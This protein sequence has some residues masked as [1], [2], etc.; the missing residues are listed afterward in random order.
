MNLSQQLQRQ[1]SY[2]KS[3]GPIPVSQRIVALKSLK[4]TIKQYE[5]ALE[6]AL[7]QDLG[8]SAFEAY[9]SEIGFIYSSIDYTIKHLKKWSRPHRV[10][11]DMAQLIGTSYVYPSAYGVVLIIGPFNYPV[12]LLLEP[13]VGAIAGGNGAILKPSELTPTVERVLVSLIET[14]FSKDYVSIVTGGV[15][16][17]QQ[18]LDLPFDY[19]FFTGSA[20]VGKIVMQKASQ[21]LIP[22]TLELGG[23]SPVI[24]DETS[25]LKLAA[26]RLAWGKFMN[27]GQTCVAPDYALVHH[28]IYDEFLSILTEVIQT[29]YGENPLLSEDYGRIV[30]TQH[31]K[32]LAKLIDENKDKLII[33]GEVSLEQ[34]YIAPTVFKDVQADDTLMTEEI[35]GPLLPTISYQSIEEIDN[36]LSLH[37]KPL[38]FY[39]FSKNQTFANQLIHRYAF[40]GGC[41]NDVVT[42]VAS[43]YLPFGGVGSSGIGRYHG[44][45]SFTTF[46]YE[47]AIVKRSTN[48]PISLVF[49]P[50]KDRLRWVK[51]IMK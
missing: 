50:Y 43:N 42:H 7:K 16:V 46:T 41:I 32:R 25:D 33:G 14:A 10:K 27:N 19:I 26:K 15:E 21:H 3:L 13:L 47:K 2:L 35:F 18:L 48:F 23:K 36:Y 37:P 4:Q 28:R 20:R 8:K 39:V 24:I 51:K 6:E 29:F 22:V 40:G 45:A 49:P 34:R 11:S 1:K 31:T 38:A 44:K 12:Q 9:T 17:N 5:I 30:T